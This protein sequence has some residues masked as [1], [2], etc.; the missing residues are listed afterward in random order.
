MADIK[1]YGLESHFNSDVTFYKNVNIN[2][3]L[4]YDSLIVRN[5]KVR[6]QASLGITTTTSLSSQ[7]LNVFNS[8]TD[9]PKG[10]I[11]KWDKGWILEDDQSLPQLTPLEKLESV[12]LTIEELKTLLGLDP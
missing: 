8:V 11:L 6:E 12:G 1:Y 5:L 3:N 9:V 7:D 2:G 4:N 10:K